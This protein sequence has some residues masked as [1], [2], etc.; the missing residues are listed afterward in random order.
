VSWFLLRRRMIKNDFVVGGAE[1]GGIAFT[2]RLKGIFPTIWEEARTTVGGVAGALT[3]TEYYGV[4]EGL[5]GW[6]CVQRTHR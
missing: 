6:N 4:V 5:G 1:D 3:K 2:W